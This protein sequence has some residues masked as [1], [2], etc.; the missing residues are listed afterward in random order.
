[1][2]TRK[3]PPLPLIDDRWLP[4]EAA[5]RRLWEED[6]DFFLAN[7]DLEAL[8]RSGKLRCKRRSKRSGKCEHV[9]PGDPLPGG[10]VYSVWGPDLDNRHQPEEPRKPPSRP[11]APRRPIPRKGRHGGLREG[12]GSRVTVAGE[13]VMRLR[14]AYRGLCAEV[15]KRGESKLPSVTRLRNSLRAARDGCCGWSDYKLRKHVR[16]PVC[17]EFPTLT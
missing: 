2:A 6:G 11:A 3:R 7:S 1:V 12:A 9:L 10:W 4:W 15:V 17:S 16:D 8:V 14:D 13:D 5:H